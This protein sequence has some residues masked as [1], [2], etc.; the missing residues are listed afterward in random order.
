MCTSDTVL[1]RVEGWKVVS[2]RKAQREGLCDKAPPAGR[3]HTLSVGA[4]GLWNVE[5]RKNKSGA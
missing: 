4:E 2:D 5:M 3:A 1:G